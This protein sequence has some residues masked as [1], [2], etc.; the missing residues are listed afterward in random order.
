MLYR[1]E[2]FLDRTVIECGLTNGKFASSKAFLFLAHTLHFILQ[3]CRIY[4]IIQLTKKN[5]I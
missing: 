5:H 3:F 4:T 2:F 1:E